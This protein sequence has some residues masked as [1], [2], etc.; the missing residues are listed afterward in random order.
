MIKT[1]QAVHEHGIIHRDIKPSNFLIGGT[2]STRN[3]VYILDFGLAK[4]YRLDNGN[5]I[6]P[7]EGKHL[8][9]T[10]KW[11]SLNTMLGYE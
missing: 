6:P 8:T 4:Y 3:I 11:A 1:I 9:G 7:K 10:A 2:Q 5:H